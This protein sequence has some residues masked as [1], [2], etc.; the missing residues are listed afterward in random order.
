VKTSEF[1]QFMIAVNQTFQVARIPERLYFCEPHYGNLG[2]SGF[3]GWNILQFR[4]ILCL[5]MEYMGTLG[6]VDLAYV[7]PEGSLDDLGGIWGADDLAWLSRYDGLRAF[8]LTALGAYVIGLENAYNPPPSG[9]TALLEVGVNQVIRHL[10]GSLQPADR[11]LL[12]AWAERI[13]ADAWRLDRMLAIQAVERGQ[14]EQWKTAWAKDHLVAWKMV[15]E[16]RKMWFWVFRSS[17]KRLHTDCRL[18]FSTGLRIT[19]P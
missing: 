1:S 6:M 14:N 8:R 11:L 2:Y 10:S 17:E 12:D 19:G 4:Y 13:E 15:S 5:L 16:I 18:G 3:G 9:S 7:H